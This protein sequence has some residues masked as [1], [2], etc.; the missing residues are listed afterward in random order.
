MRALESG[1]RIAKLL[2]R[3]LARLGRAD[4]EQAVP[5]LGDPLAQHALLADDSE[6]MDIVP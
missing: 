6:G 2:L 3:A 1:Q 4:A 5:G